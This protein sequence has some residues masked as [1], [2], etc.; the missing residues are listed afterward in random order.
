MCLAGYCSR[1]W[2]A[3]SFAMLRGCLVGSGWFADVSLDDEWTV[4][5]AGRVLGMV[6][7]LF[8]WF[9]CFRLGIM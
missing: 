5:I 8:Y 1:F 2:R 7:L 9:A 4:W 3:V 6:G